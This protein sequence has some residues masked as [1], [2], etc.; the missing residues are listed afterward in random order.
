MSAVP[1]VSKTDGKVNFGN[2]PGPGPGRPVGLPNKMTVAA[3][4]AF[5]LAFQGL[6]GVDALIEWGKENRTEFYKLYA[7][8]IPQTLIGSIGVY[9]ATADAELVKS[10]LL[11]RV[12]A[13]I[14]GRPVLEHAGGGLAGDQVRLEPVGEAEPETPAG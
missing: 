8:L 6:G 10:R 7:R 11:A 2:L 12:A 13:A 14:E 4:E 1:E 9:D 3:K 5:N